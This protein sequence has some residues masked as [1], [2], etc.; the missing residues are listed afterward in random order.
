MYEK[1]DILDRIFKGNSKYVSRSG[2][3]T[4]SFYPHFTLKVPGALYVIMLLIWWLFS[5]QPFGTYKT[6][7]EMFAI[8]WNKEKRKKTETDLKK[9]VQNFKTWNS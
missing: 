4:L 3:I 9:K 8:K 2:F 1:L 7:K 6:L 5:A